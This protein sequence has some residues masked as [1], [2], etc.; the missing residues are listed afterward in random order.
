MESLEIAQQ[1]DVIETIANGPTIALSN[2]FITVSFYR[3]VFFPN[4][5]L[6][7]SAS[8]GSHRL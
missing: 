7:S 5:Y 6:I 2:V 8:R 3:S 4:P 1:W